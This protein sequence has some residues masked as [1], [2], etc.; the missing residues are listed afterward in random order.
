MPYLEGF[1]ITTLRASKGAFR[2]TKMTGTQQQSVLTVSVNAAIINQRLKELADDAVKGCGCSHDVYVQKFSAAVDREFNAS[3]DGR[4]SAIEPLARALDYATPEEIEEEIRACEAMGYC[5]HGIERNC[6]PAGCGDIEDPAEIAA[7]EA[8]EAEMWETYYVEATASACA[9]LREVSHS[10]R[11]ACG[12]FDDRS[13]LDESRESR[14]RELFTKAVDGLLEAHGYELGI[15]SLDNEHYSEVLDH[16]ARL[17]Y[18]L[19]VNIDPSEKTTAKFGRI[20]SV[21]TGLVPVWMRKK[22]RSVSALH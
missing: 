3:G 14:Y 19:S 17:G 20:H 7:Y 1:Q 9:K 4:W 6:C 11:Q 21:L 10:I 2:R 8:R 5:S 16:A 13:V 22:T 18:D 12:E 15:E